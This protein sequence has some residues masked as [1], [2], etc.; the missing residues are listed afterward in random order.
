MPTSPPTSEQVLTLLAATPPRI[1]A[2]TAGLPPAHVQTRPTPEEWSANEVLAHLRACAD[3]WGGCIAAMLAQDTPTLRAVDPRTWIRQTDYPEQEFQPSLHAFAMQ[4]TE[5]LA[6]LEP[7]ECDQN[8]WRPYCLLCRAVRRRLH[9]PLIL[10]AL[11]PLSPAGWSRAATVTGAGKVLERT[12]LSYAQRLARHERP[13]VKQI[14][15]IVD[16]LRR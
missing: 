5:L 14:E 8:Q 3:V 15:R 4:R 1:A 2:L 10:V 7:L 9:V 12:V 6:V 13:H 11:E 16:T